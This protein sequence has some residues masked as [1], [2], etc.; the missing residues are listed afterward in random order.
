MKLNTIKGRIAA[1]QTLP[2]FWALAPKPKF[3]SDIDAY[4]NTEGEYVTFSVET[5][6]VYPPE[7]FLPSHVENLQRQGIP[8]G[9]PVA[10]NGYPS[11]GKWKTD[12][13]HDRL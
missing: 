1:S 9:T 11:G 7:K 13:N 12:E 2:D 10:L 5:G 3:G 4:W 6:K 8:E